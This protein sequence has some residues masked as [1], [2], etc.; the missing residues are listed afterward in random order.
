MTDA[1]STERI[2]LVDDNPTNLQVLF[3]TLQGTGYE[4]LIATGGEEAIDIVR[5]A[6]PTIVLLDIMMPPGID[7]YTTL[8]RLKADP[9][10]AQTAVIFL[11]ALDDTADKVRGL[12]LGAVDYVSKP[13]QAE[14]VVARVETHVKLRRLERELTSKNDALRD[15][16]EHLEDKVRERSA[17]LLRSR[18][19]VIFGL[20]KLAE[21][22][23]DDTG[24]HLER[25]CR[26]VE[27]LAGDIASGS[28]DVDEVWV[29]IVT[30]TAA[31]HDIGK[32]GVPDAVLCKPG[33][34]TD[35]ERTEIQKHTII[36][37][38]TLLALKRKWGDDEFLVTATQ[39][40]FGHHER[41]DGG[42][43][44]FGLAGE[45]IP[46]SARIVAVCDV[47][48]ALTS[49]RVYKPAMTH[50]EASRIISEGAGAHFD[51]A[52]VEAFHRVADRFEGVARS[53]REAAS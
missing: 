53:V 38:D 31:L 10:T 35:E 43:Y 27:I 41:W 46:L 30:S 16:N 5:S 50:E 12:Q 33:K 36:G 17:A 44:P 3:Q 29:Q 25:I 4:L 24:Q 32:V 21:S 49:K 47:Y 26:Y 7:G 6:Q 1:P 19:A 14:E 20:A 13:F 28:A 9:E 34:L 2:L 23:D 42:G 37:G 22:R 52:V 15:L 11:S 40:A 39:I 18:D 8:E 48:D 45:D 51:P